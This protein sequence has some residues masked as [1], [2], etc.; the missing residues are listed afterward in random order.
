MIRGSS[1]L[2]STPS[3]HQASRSSAIEKQQSGAL[4]HVL[5]EANALFPKKDWLFALESEGIG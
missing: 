2:G 5:T 4:L 3:E 1:S